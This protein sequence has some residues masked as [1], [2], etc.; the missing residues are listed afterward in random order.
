MSDPGTDPGPDAA[1]DLDP[2]D[3]AAT[4]HESDESL[5]SMLRGVCVSRAKA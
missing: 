3:A 2:S 1:H 5:R 4:P